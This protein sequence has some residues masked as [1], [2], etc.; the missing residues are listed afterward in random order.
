MLRTRPEKPAIGNMIPF[1]VGSWDGKVIFGSYVAFLFL[2][3]IA[4]S[5]QKLCTWNE[6]LKEYL[7]RTGS[8][9]AILAV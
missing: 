6:K 5:T 1:L 4:V 9:K 2:G 8:L 7:L 3:G